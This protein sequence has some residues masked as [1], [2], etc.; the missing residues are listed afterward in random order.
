MTSQGDIVE[1]HGAT[2]G[3]P[4]SQDLLPRVIT[5]GQQGLQAVFKMQ[6]EAVAGGGV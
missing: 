5:L 3:V 6:R 2:E 1:V 4:F